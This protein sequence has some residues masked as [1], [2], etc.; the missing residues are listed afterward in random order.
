[1]EH[2]NGYL[3]D[4]EQSLLRKLI[5]FDIFSYPLLP[6]E[7]MLYC[8]YPNI[9][10]GEALLALQELENKN[11]INFDRGYYYLG[12]D[13]SKIDR[14]IE[15]NRLAD[16]RIGTAIKYAKLIANFPFVKAVLISGS[17]SKHFMKPDSDIDFFLITEPGKLWLCRMMLT[18]FK[19]IFL[20][21]SFKNFC[22]NYFIDANSLE[23]PD[24]NVFTAT[25]IAFL[26]PMYNFHLYEKFMKANIWYRSEYPNIPY[27]QEL[28]EIDPNGIKKILEFPFNNWIG[29]ILD[30]LSFI[31]IK[32]FWQKKFRHF[33]KESFELN[34]RSHKNVSKHHP[35][36][37]QEKVLK[38][39]TE[40][41]RLFEA[42]T[43]YNY[44]V[45]MTYETYISE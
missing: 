18:L 6:E 43:R 7:I 10:K 35:L 41:I 29:N 16:E 45:A 33:N 2:S 25:E 9:I 20:L 27:H 40:K 19:K 28:I 36:T 4:I 38:K 23:I 14:R 1:M 3:T 42:D 22:L 8:D 39:Y 32:G 5:Y 30:Q 21:N 17:L 11:L 13:P 15:G 44:T 34:F 26:L 37:F 24:K 12:N 31:V